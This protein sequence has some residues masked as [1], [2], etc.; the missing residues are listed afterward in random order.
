MRKFKTVFMRG[1]TSKGCMFL[2]SDLPENMIPVMM[3]GLGYPLYAC[4]CSRTEEKI[5]TGI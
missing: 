3:L 1:G 5:K 4:C 2:R